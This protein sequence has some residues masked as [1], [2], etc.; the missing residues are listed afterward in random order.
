MPSRRHD[1]CL[2]RTRQY[3][4][5]LVNGQPGALLKTADGALLTVVSLDIVGGR[6]KEIRSILNPDKLD[7]LGP[8]AD[9]NELLRA[10]RRSD[11]P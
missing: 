10:W 1:R 7:H 4:Q 2:R 3:A 11:N 9:A 6:I 5:A 8:V